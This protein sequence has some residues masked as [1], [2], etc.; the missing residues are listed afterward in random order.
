M[1][2]ARWGDGDVYVFGSSNG[3][4]CMECRLKTPDENG[5]HNDF[6]CQ[7]RQEL[8]DH[9]NEHVRQDHDVPLRAFKRLIAEIAEEH[10]G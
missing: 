3:F 8:L 7:T 1:S 9:L 2:Y 4:T 5:W 6:M 10:H